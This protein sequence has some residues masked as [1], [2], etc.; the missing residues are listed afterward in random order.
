MRPRRRPPAGGRPVATGGRARS[1]RDAPADRQ[2]RE[3]RDGAR[4]AASAARG[5]G[6]LRG[7]AK[8]PTATAKAPLAPKPTRPA[9]ARSRPR[10]A[11][12]PKTAPFPKGTSRLRPRRPPKTAPFPRASRSPAISPPI[13]NVQACSGSPRPRRA[14]GA[15]DA[16]PA[17][18]VRPARRRA[19][20]RAGDQHHAGAG[21]VPDHPAAAA[22]QRQLVTQ[23]QELEVQVAAD[24]SAPV[25]EQRAYQLGMRPRR[26]GPVPGPART[27]RS[28][29]TP[30]GG[31]ERRTNVPGYVP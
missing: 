25:I 19:G 11:Q 10:A 18:G 6:R 4:A 13:H 27:A 30:A 1:P 16:V 14:G 12:P 5:L 28:R 8:A 26:H 3:R 9:R 15:A 7:T 2:G 23:R 17:A 31:G 24:R 29:P 21:V 22:G 20:L